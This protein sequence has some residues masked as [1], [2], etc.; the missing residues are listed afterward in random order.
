MVRSPAI[1]CGAVISGVDK[2]FSAELRSSLYGRRSAQFRMASSVGQRAWPMM[3]DGTNLRRHLG[4]AS[5]QRSVRCQDA[6]L[7]PQ[8]FLRDSGYRPFQIGKSITFA[9]E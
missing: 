1:T 2:L 3:S 5:A 7:L 8:H 9:P 4:V 6:K